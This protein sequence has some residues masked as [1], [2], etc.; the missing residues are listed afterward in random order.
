MKA[1]AIRLWLTIVLALSGLTLAARPAAR[2]EVKSFS[3]YLVVQ[4]DGKY[5]VKKDEYVKFQVVNG[6]IKGLRIHLQA[7]TGDLTFTDIRP[8]VKDGSNFT[9][10]FEI[11]CRRLGGFEGRP[12]TYDYFL[13]DAYAGISPPV[14]TSYSMYNALKEVAG[15]IGWPVP[16]RTFV[17]YGQNRSPIYEFFCYEDIN[18]GKNN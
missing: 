11:E 6:E 17:I 5:R 15:A 3:G 2:T 16:G 18:D 14:A 10:W 13:A 12:V 8:L 9:D 1:T 7:A 4:E